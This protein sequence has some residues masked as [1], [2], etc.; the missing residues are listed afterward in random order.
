MMSAF[1]L[2]I[3]IL[4][5]TIGSVWG[6]VEQWQISSTSS[7]GGVLQFQECRAVTQMTMFIYVNN[8]HVPSGGH[9]ES[10]NG[11]KSMSNSAE[12]RHYWSDRGGQFTW[13]DHLNRSG[14]LSQH[15][16]LDKQISADLFGRPTLIVT[17][18]GKRFIGLLQTYEDNPDWV[19][20]NIDGRVVRFYINTIKELYQVKN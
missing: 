7:D 4:F 3:I 17:Q 9:T 15:T 13:W 1:A 5:S 10:G 18:K 20:L 6:C 2:T 12:I 8:N 16:V 14:R 19:V 11:V